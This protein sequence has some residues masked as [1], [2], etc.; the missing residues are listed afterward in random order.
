MRFEDI[1][2]YLKLRSLTTNPWEIC[3]FR[4]GQKPGQT[5]VVQFRDK[6]HLY[7]RGGMRD[8]HMFHRIFLRDEYRLAGIPLQSWECVVDL[9]ANVGIFSSRV[10]ELARKVFSYEPF[11]GNREQLEKNLKTREN[12]TVIHKAVAEKPGIIRLFM[13]E[14]KR[15]T[16]SYSSFPDLRVSTESYQEVPSITLN[17]IFDD[18]KIFRCDLLKIDIEG[19]E[20]EVLHS[21]DDEVLSRTMRIHGEY[22]NVEPDNEITRIDNF[23]SFLR[24]KDYDVEVVPHKRKPN[25]GMFYATRVKV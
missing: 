25:H 21:T 9:G 6:P 16:G 22:H 8:Y 17:Q 12:I 15:C 5:L 23:T 10:S 3:C 1:N 4:K 13:P 24:S 19:Q 7:L 18:N 11:P 2:D 14:S 20:Y